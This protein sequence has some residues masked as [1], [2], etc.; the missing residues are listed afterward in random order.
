MRP[1]DSLQEQLQQQLLK[2]NQA[3]KELS[4]CLQQNDE[5]QTKIR[6][7]ETLH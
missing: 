2:Y 5:L 7:Q 6:E 4:A 3:L 1:I